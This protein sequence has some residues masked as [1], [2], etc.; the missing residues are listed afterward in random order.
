MFYYVK[1]WWFY[2]R[3]YAVRPD[4]NYSRTPTCATLSDVCTLSPR[5]SA[6]IKRGESL[7]YNDVNFI[8][9]QQEMLILCEALIRWKLKWLLRWDKA[10]GFRFKTCQMKIL[11]TKTRLWQITIRIF[12]DSGVFCLLLSQVK[13]RLCRWC[14]YCFLTFCVVIVVDI[15]IKFND[16]HYC[17]NMLLFFLFQAH[18]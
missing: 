3:V 8:V 15:F 12:R 6:A 4:R 16:L 7:L 13:M 14:S 11:Q 5:C 18:R 10:T 9:T 17:Y 2:D 1:A